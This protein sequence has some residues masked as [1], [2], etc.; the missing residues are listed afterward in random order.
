MGLKRDM[1][2]QLISFSPG[3]GHC[4]DILD[5]RVF[6]NQFPPKPLSI[7]LGPFRIFSKFA[8]IFAAQG[9]PCTGVFGTSG[10]PDVRISPQ[11]S[12]KIEVTLMLFSGA[13]GR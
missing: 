1:V 13:W 5:Y 12:K 9:A 10:A 3:K 8:E 11:I 4:H 6:Q 2:N 7:P